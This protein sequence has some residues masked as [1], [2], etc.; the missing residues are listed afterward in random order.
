MDESR[1]RYRSLSEGEGDTERVWRAVALR[2]YTGSTHAVVRDRIGSSRASTLPVINEN[3][4][5]EG[6]MSFAL[7][8]AL[9]EV[10]I[11]LTGKYSGRR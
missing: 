10:H 9:G 8:S 7:F 11:L 4:L 2:V 3:E 6:G 1:L 5:S